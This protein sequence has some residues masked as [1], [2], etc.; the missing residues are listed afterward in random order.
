MH[1]KILPC[2]AMALGLAGVVGCSE[3]S[4]PDPATGGNTTTSTGTGGSTGGTGGAGGAGGGA[5]NVPTVPEA[6]QNLE[7]HVWTPISLNTL[8]DVDPCPDRDCGYSAVEGQSAVL[9]DWTGGAFA[10]A[11]GDH[12]GL[13]YFGGGHNGYY[14][15]E[16]YLF[17]IGT[18]SWTRASEPTVGQTPGDATT[19]DL[20]QDTC[21][22]YD[23]HPLAFHT[24]DSVAYIPTTRRFFLSALG[25]APSQPPGLVTGCSSPVGMMYDFAGADW[26]AVGDAIPVSAKYVPTAYDESRDAVWVWSQA[27]PW[28]LQQYDVASDTWTEHGGDYLSS[29]DAVGAIDPGR[30]LFVVCEFR[31]GH[32]VLVKDLANPDAEALSVTTAGDTEIQQ[33]GQVGFEWMPSLGQFVAWHAGSA[34]YL[35]EP[36]SGDWSTGTWQ[37]TRVDLTG[38]PP[39]DPM[40]GPFS[41][42]QVA[43]KLGIALVATK[44][45]EAVHAVR[46]VAV[47]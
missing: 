10:S 1:K 33:H 31:S 4:N 36:P 47:E 23:G 16:V 15:N 39:T 42:F 24:Y 2:W 29:I 3:E 35:L 12:G 25:D 21:L 27:S 38:T 8:A 34:I 9:N 41:K 32:E 13:I 26:V 19:F 43:P 40:N 11:E 22:Y 17:D 5:G 20:G 44:R 45:D 46:L 28:S 7:L 6:I 30:D 37:W 18:L 14:G